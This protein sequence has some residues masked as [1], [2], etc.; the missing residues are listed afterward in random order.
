MTYVG[1]IWYNRPIMHVPASAC[2][3]NLR[4][5]GGWRDRKQQINQSPCIWLIGA[6]CIECAAQMLRMACIV[7]WRELPSSL[8]QMTPS[9]QSWHARGEDDYSCVSLKKE[10]GGAVCKTQSQRIDHHQL[11]MQLEGVW[12][13]ILPLQPFANCHR[14]GS[15]LQR[16]QRNL[17][18]GLSLPL[19]HPSSFL[20]RHHICYIYS[21]CRE[22]TSAP[23]FECSQQGSS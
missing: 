2:T 11:A 15:W 23:T 20:R 13:L 18:L 8:L 6:P 16:M 9:C 17:I 1:W 14:P 3:E 12:K 5:P 10:R 21:A 22:C 19:L 4:R 7:S